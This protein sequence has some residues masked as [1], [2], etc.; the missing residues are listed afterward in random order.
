[1]THRARA[2]ILLQWLVG[3]ALIGVVAGLASALFLWL[4][5]VATQTRTAHMALV[6]SLPLA[7]LVLG[8]IYARLGQSI[9]GGSNLVLDT[10]HDGG[11][12]LP[13][14]LAPLVLLGTVLTHLFGGSAGREGTAVQMGAGLTDWLTHRFRVSPALRRQLLCAGVAAGFG[15]VFGTPLAGAVFGLEFVV[16]GRLQHTALV[17]ALVASVV[18]D[19]T[20]RAC[21]ITHTA[22]PPAPDLAVSPLVLGKWLLFA[23]AVAVVAIAFIELT[24]AIK[25]HAALRLPSL[26]W[27]M[28]AGGVAVLA[29]WQLAGTDD[30]LGLGVPTI[31]R[32]FVD[33]ALPP[34][35]FAWKLLFTALTLGAGFL[36]GEVTP[37]FFVGAA[38]GNVLSHHLG[39]PLAL[40][41]GVGL[42][43][44]FGAAANTPLALTVMAAELLGT[45]ILPHVAIVCA[46]SY[47]LTGHRSIYT[48][49][50][51][52]RGKILRTVTR[53]GATLLGVLF[54]VACQK[55][56][57]P[58]L[59]P[60]TADT[61]QA[62]DTPAPL[63]SPATTVVQP[64]LTDPDLLEV[65]EDP[66][67]FVGR[68]GHGGGGHTHSMGTAQNGTLL[69]GVA[70]RESAT[71]R[72]LPQT[73]ARGFYFGTAELVDLLERSAAGVAEDFPGSRLRVANLSR[74]G[75]GDIPPSVS[76][77]SGRDADV[78]FFAFDR[79]GSDASPANFVHFDDNGLSDA[80]EVGR[81]EFDTARNWGLVR[82]WLTDPSVVVQ[83]IFV[84]VPL[85]NR[86][87]DYAL[88]QREPDSLRQRAMRVLVQPR[89]SSPHAD[90]FHVRIACP[91][92][93]RPACIDGY[94]QTSRAREAQVDAL[95]EMYTHGSPAEQRYARELLTLPADGGDAELPPIEGGEESGGAGGG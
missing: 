3:G 53:P 68:F 19:W 64:E 9:R 38:L 69:D 25:K 17:P 27:R 36:G 40:G 12:Q 22:Y 92:D 13:L 43:A 49:Q 95:L 39:L 44:V 80:G 51:V 59:P 67:P 14:R 62:P 82:R 4:L 76:H 89:D 32:A 23:V 30:Y 90:H 46:V 77:N 37:L 54:V 83:W 45:P 1:M 60:P 74:H 70:L 48:A 20:T 79:S 61:V 81:W 8:A 75:G 33:P 21:G 41:A 29:L 94:G 84:S 7:G 28:A 72:I 56:P 65:L 34:T 63:P 47:V 93:D 52:G 5:D 42:A 15:S 31:V 73:R 88:R 58:V 35:A 11:P 66:L 87:L 57:A 55:T 6:W 85:R 78:P 24:H 16:L 86:L 10:I 2:Q 91:A 50:R 71:L 18:G 26:P